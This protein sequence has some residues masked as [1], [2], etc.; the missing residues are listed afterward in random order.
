M[1]PEDYHQQAVE[2]AH[3][4]RDEQR[5]RIRALGDDEPPAG[6]RVVWL[7]TGSGPGIEILV[8]ED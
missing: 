8:P 3:A 2:A 4:W 1:T 6:F 7:D 5:A